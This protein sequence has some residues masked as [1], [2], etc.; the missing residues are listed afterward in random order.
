MMKGKNKD[1]MYKMIG[2]PVLSGVAA[3]IKDKVNIGL[4]LILKSCISDGNV[5]QEKWVKFNEMITIFGD[6]NMVSKGCS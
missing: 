3:V 6:E 4:K 5:R 1:N 2:D